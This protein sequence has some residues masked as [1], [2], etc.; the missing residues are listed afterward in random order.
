MDVEST[1][2]IKVEHDEFGGICYSCELANLFCD[3]T[4]FRRKESVSHLANYLVR[5]QVV[6]G[7]NLLQGSSLFFRG[8]KIH[9]AFLTVERINTIFHIAEGLRHPSLRESLCFR[10]SG[11]CGSTIFSD[12]R[13]I[14]IEDCQ[15]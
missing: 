7:S 2:I 8:P 15:I 6:L 4:G 5:S 1:I 10:V 14:R 11:H 13:S 12:K 9:H 3:A